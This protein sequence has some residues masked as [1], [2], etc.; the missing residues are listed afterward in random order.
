MKK[1]DC[2]KYVIKNNDKTKSSMVRRC[3]DEITTK[4]SRGK[5]VR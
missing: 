2:S 1:V 4:K 3:L 5:R